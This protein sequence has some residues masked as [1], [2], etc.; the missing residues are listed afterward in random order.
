MIDYRV[1]QKVCN[2]RQWIHYF[3]K[4][5]T[6]CI[7]YS[8]SQI[9]RTRLVQLAILL[10]VY[11]FGKTVLVCAFKLYPFTL[12]T[13]ATLG[14]CII[15]SLLPLTSLDAM[16]QWDWGIVLPIL[17]FFCITEG[18]QKEEVIFVVT[19]IPLFLHLLTSILPFF[20]F[21]WCAFNNCL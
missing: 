12:F 10:F 14:F 16:W 6:S 18:P 17:S 7:R 4:F 9:Y 8:F 3:Y 11:L 1:V 21:V 5:K 20:F 19:C 15:T 13:L 2:G